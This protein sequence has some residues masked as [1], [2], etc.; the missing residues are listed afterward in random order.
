MTQ[1][2]SSG[3]GDADPWSFLPGVPLGVARPELYAAKGAFFGRPR[4]RMQSAPKPP[5]FST[6]Q[7]ALSELLFSARGFHTIA[8]TAGRMLDTLLIAGLETTHSF[9]LG[10]VL[11]LENPSL[12][13]TR[14]DYTSFR[15]S[16]RGWSA[17]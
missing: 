15:R 11:D 9:T 4:S 17:V 7:H 14:R 12:R 1:P 5:S 3:P 13:R 2:G 10:V 6:S 16:R 8:R